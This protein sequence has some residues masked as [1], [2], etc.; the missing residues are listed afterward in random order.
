MLAESS[1]TALLNDA[2][3]HRVG[4]WNSTFRKSL[5]RLEAEY[6]E[7]FLLFVDYDQTV[8]KMLQSITS[9]ESVTSKVGEVET[10]DVVKLITLTIYAAQLSSHRENMRVLLHDVGGVISSYRSQSN[11]LTVNLIAV[12]SLFVALISLLVATLALKR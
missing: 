3:Q 8:T 12:I 4:F 1:L 11:N 6:D 10:V 5:E 7:A 9:T 2:R